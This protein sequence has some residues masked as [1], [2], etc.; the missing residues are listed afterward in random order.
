MPLARP[1]LFAAAL[2]AGLSGAVAATA[3]GS[4][5]PAWLSAVVLT[6]TNSHVLGNPRAPLKLAAYVSYTCSHCAAFDRESDAPLKRNFVAPGKL[7]L[8]IK[9]LI[10]DPI[11]ATVAQLANCGPKEKFFGNHAAFMHGQGQWLA[12]ATTASQ[13]QLQRWS[14]GDY[15]A[16]RR[17]IA[18]DLGLYR[19]MAARG[20]SRVQLDRCLA[21]EAL[22]R[23]LAAQTAEAAKLGIDSTPSFALNGAPLI[24]THD[25]RTLEVQLGA[26]D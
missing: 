26:R 9:H 24:G 8:E 7:S 11:D 10:R 18:T 16:R 2:L 17:A 5:T 6:P 19:V 12:G 14:S 20:Y 25:W 15:A 13:A 23:R 22:A 1:A 3:S 4:G 21:D